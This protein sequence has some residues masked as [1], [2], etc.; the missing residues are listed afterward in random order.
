MVEWTL[1]DGAVVIG[2]DQEVWS[3]DQLGERL[4]RLES[5]G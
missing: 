5:L 3:I 1:D 2:E 4:R